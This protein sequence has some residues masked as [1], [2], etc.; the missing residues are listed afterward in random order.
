[1]TLLNCPLFGARIPTLSL[2]YV[3]RVIAIFDKIPPQISLAYLLHNE[4]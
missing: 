2:S 4:K 3:S 1:M